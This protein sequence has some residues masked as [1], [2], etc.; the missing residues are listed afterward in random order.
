MRRL[1]ALTIL[2]TV[3]LLALPLQSKAMGRLT[4]PE[5]AIS[6]KRA[7][8][9]P[10][11]VRRSRRRLYVHRH[12]SHFVADGYARM[13]VIHSYPRGIVPVFGCPRPC[14]GYHHR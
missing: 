3:A 8:H 12:R 7:A 9:M 6:L 10:R 11:G 5:G 4:K 1:I 13:Y 14:H 2:A